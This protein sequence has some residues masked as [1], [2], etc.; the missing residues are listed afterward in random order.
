MYEADKNEVLAS[1]ADAFSNTVDQL[2][3]EARGF[4][5]G[6]EIDLSGLVV[7]GEEGDPQSLTVFKNGE[8]ETWRIVDPDLYQSIN[9][10]ADAPQLGDLLKKI[11]MP[12]QWLKSS[13]TNFPLF[14]IKN[15]ARDSVNTWMISQGGVN[16]MD[17]LNKISGEDKNAFN[18]YGGSQA[19]FHHSTEAGYMD[20]MEQTMKQI[21]AN[22]GRVQDIRRY[23]KFSLANYRSKL[24][25]AE[26]RNRL[27]EFQKVKK[28]ALDKYGYDEYNANML[29]AFHAR[30]LMDF[31]VAGHW[32]R[33][34][35]RWIPFSN[36]WIQGMRRG[37]KSLM[38]NPL[39]YGFRT[40]IYTLMPTALMHAMAYLFD[41]DDEYEDL[42]AWQRDLHWN[43]KIPGVTD[44]ISIP[45]PFE[46]GA[47]STVFDRMI[48]DYK[49]VENP[50]A[51]MQ[52]S[53][54]TTFIAFDRWSLSG[55]VKPF[56]EGASNYSSFRQGPI[57]KQTNKPFIS[58]KGREE[59]S[60]LSQ[61]LT[62]AFG[63]TDPYADANLTDHYIRSYT[64]YLGA[65][66]QKA[67]D[68]GK[69][70]SRY[71]FG[72]PYS[73]GLM[74]QLNPVGKAGGEAY[75]LTAELQRW[76]DKKYLK[77]KQ[78]LDQYY[79]IQ[80]KGVLGIGTLKER[81]AKAKEIRDYLNN[82]YLP[83]MRE[84]KKEED[85]KKRA[86]YLEKKQKDL[87]FKQEK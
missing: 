62:S 25:G 14:A 87:L 70:N 4:D 19:G 45:K 32:M 55:P 24:E 86:E 6:E 28:I 21:S 66:A 43:F 48:S 46:N 29:A 69:E 68:I 18:T 64:S 42:P 61:N 65:L 5:R 85:A 34:I 59:A 15:F 40:F 50:Y 27:L 74:R 78:M 84:K 16:P 23:K 67:G 41:Y 57:T 12:N 76:N 22:G 26:N 8:K 11:T 63:L 47:W 36:A 56:L 60:R 3:K 35:N 9:A 39:K 53:L 7:R 77:F 81:E 2:G 10:L 30:D 82:D 71:K 1:W 72:L 51:G 31:A 83:Y 80:G 52:E 13:I 54:G 73:T 37:G 44:W 75:E 33:A 58:R 49:G 38:N 20:M 17:T 79:E